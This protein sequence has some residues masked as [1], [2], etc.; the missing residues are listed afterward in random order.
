MELNN[1]SL[2]QSNIGY[3]F[4]NAVFVELLRAGYIP[5]TNL[6]QLKNNDASCVDFYIRKDEEKYLIQASSS[7]KDNETRNREFKALKNSNIEGV[8]KIV[9]VLENDED[10]LKEN[11]IGV[12]SFENLAKFLYTR[13]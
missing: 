4:E 13:E 9:V 5:Q 7:I 8:R 12:V 3:L 2:F 11:D 6:F 1:P 10:N